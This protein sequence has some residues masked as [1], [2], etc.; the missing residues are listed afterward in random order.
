MKKP[1]R[2]F[3]NIS[4]YEQD[5]LKQRAADKG[6]NLSNLVR[7]AL[8]LPAVRHGVKTFDIGA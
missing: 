8:K 5:Q 1:I 4:Q 6:V 3:I 2:L 7:K